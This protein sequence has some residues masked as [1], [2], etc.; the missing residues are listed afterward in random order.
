MQRPELILTGYNH[1]LQQYNTKTLKFS[2]GTTLHARRLDDGAHYVYAMDN[3]FVNFY[4]TLMSM[5]EA[6]DYQIACYRAG[7]FCYPGEVVLVTALSGLPQ[8]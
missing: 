6:C 3:R 8:Q 7:K 4:Q 1:K 5:E 2:D